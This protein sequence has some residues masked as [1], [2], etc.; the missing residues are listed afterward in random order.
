MIVGDLYASAD[1]AV[2]IH[3]FQMFAIFVLCIM[4]KALWQGTTEAIQFF[5]NKKFFV[6]LAVR[7][8]VPSAAMECRLVWLDEHDLS[9]IFEKSR[10]PI[11][12]LW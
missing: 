4:L 3:I 6:H 1:G 8:C 7:L 11:F 9:R 2:E 10:S 12:Q 5:Q